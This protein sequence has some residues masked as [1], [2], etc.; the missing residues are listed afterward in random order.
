MS[1]AMSDRVAGLLRPVGHDGSV[2]EVVSRMPTP[3]LLRYRAVDRE[4]VGSNLVDTPKHL[5]ALTEE[6][7]IHGIRVPLRFGFNHEFA[8]LDG[9]H[10]IAA[11]LRLGLVEVPVM[12]VR[13][14][15]SPR[16]AHAQ[17]M[18]P[19]DLVEIE[20]AFDATQ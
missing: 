1:A 18:R 2:R 10:R 17:P 20:R 12:L 3:M 13:E 9:N 11:A 16:P 4:F 15:L 14:P 5:D 19:E 6:I 8:T 7:R